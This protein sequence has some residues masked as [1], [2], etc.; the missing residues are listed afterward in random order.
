MCTKKS[1]SGSFYIIR[2]NSKKLQRKTKTPLCFA[3]GYNLRAFLAVIKFL[4]KKIFKKNFFTDFANKVIFQSNEKLVGNILE[5]Y[6]NLIKFDKV[7]RKSE[8]MIDFFSN[9]KRNMYCYSFFL[10]LI[11]KHHLDHH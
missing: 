11:R 10:Y 3:N 7:Y 9:L 6:Q 8:I 2:K 5:S 4:E 1:F